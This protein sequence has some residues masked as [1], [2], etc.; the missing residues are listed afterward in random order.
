[1]ADKF[2]VTK[3]NTPLGAAKWPKLSE[4]DY[5]TKDYPKPDGEY[6]TKMIFDATDPKFVAF[7]ER[8]EAYIAPVEAMAQAKF[9][10]LKKPQRDKLGSPTFNDMFVPIYDEDDEPTGEVE[11][12]FTMKAG[13]VVKK[14]PREGS[15]WSRKPNLFDSLGRPIKGKVDIWGGS[16][17]IIAFSF[18]DD[19]YWIP[20][21]GAYGIKL[22]LEAAQ[23]VTLR[24]A[25]ARNAG[26]YGFGEQE[27][28]FDASQHTPAQTDGS[29]DE[30]DGDD[31]YNTT[32]SGE[33]ESEGDPA[34]ASDF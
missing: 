31:E 5:G 2:K 16:E 13:G 34:G 33:G 18:T 22:Q 25:G 4:P 1:M 24:E 32:P 23:I 15:K 11:M 6:S 26:D 21:T 12:K 27:G 17:L 20:A 3:L 7:R 9:A 8:M 19:G 10:E 30:E 29:D 28:G 14:G